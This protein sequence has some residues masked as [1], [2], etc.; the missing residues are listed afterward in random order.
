MA[1]MNPNHRLCIFATDCLRD[2][3]LV[4]IAKLSIVDTLELGAFLCLYLSTSEAT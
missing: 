4:K 3:R 1:K 2:E